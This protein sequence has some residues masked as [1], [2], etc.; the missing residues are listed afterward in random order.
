MIPHRP[1]D[2]IPIHL[3]HSAERQALADHDGS[4][5]AKAARDAAR[6]AIDD[7]DATL[8]R[9]IGLSSAALRPGRRLGEHSLGD[10]SLGREVLGELARR[11]RGER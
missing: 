8:L 4:N 11:M 9:T 6:R 5:W 1:P 10:D 7:P 2:G 3:L